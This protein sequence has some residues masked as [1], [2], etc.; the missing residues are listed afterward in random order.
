M[1]NLRPVQ[2]IVYIYP[3]LSLSVLIRALVQGKLVPKQ[4]ACQAPAINEKSFGPKAAI[5]RGEGY[6]ERR[7]VFTQN[8]I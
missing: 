7:E 3:Y 1:H 4:L 8:L 6:L 5:R 2:R